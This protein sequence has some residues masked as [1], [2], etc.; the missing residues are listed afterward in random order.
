MALRVPSLEREATVMVGRGPVVSR[1]QDLPTFRLAQNLALQVYT[2]ALRQPHAERGAP[3]RAVRR[4]ARAAVAGIAGAADR[5]LHR[6]AVVSSLVSAQA[7]CDEVRVH[8]DLLH[9]TA[10]LGDLQHRLLHEGYLR[11]GAML[12][13]LTAAAEAAGQAALWVTLV[14]AHRPGRDEA[15]RDR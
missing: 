4:V 2:L 8:L 6:R 1:H 15:E 10:A 5:P 12:A 9:E 13:A 7:S 14:P 11:L 3:A